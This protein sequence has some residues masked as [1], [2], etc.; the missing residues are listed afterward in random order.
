MMKK[1]GSSCSTVDDGAARDEEG[2]VM[3]KAV[4][5]SPYRTGYHNRPIARVIHASILVLW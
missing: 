1:E 5:Q 3:K 4:A 2:H